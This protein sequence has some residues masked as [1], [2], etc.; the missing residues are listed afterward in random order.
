MAGSVCVAVIHGLDLSFPTRPCCPQSR[1][2][3]AVLV[4]V[5]EHVVH[6]VHATLVRLVTEGTL[7]VDLGTALVGGGHASASPSLHRP[8][9]VP[10]LSEDAFT[11]TGLR[12]ASSG[13][14]LHNCVKKACAVRGGAEWAAEV[15]GRS[16]AHAQ[17]LAAALSLCLA[18]LDGRLTARVCGT[19]EVVV[20][21]IGAG[22]EGMEGVR[23]QYAWVTCLRSLPLFK[24]V[25]ARGCGCG[26]GCGCGVAVAVAVGGCVGV[27]VGVCFT[28]GVC[29][30]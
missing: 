2:L 10:T 19:H 7:S 27:G 17:E 13:P 23:L 30:T 12:L 14:R 4:K 15:A 6:H 26:C 9:L 25:S 18:A 20:V 3:P 5:Q 1:P 11:D 24:E 28:E 21:L 16:A 8:L 22:L 29:L